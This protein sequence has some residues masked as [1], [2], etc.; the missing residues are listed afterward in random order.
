MASDSSLR[1]SIIKA[2]QLHLE[3]CENQCSNH[4][5]FGFR[6]NHYYGTVPVD[7]QSIKKNK[8]L[9]VHFS[10]TVNFSDGL[11]DTI[12]NF[13]ICLDHTYRL[14][15]GNSLLDSTCKEYIYVPPSSC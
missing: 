8:N 14:L 12:Q 1:Q 3:V 13:K 5:L 6:L 11:T 2:L 9:K 7:C 15:L 4:N 10:K